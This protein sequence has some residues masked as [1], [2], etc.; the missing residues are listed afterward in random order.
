MTFREFRNGLCILR[1]LDR[2]ALVEAGVI[3]HGDHIRWLA[4]KDSPYE[5]TLEL[6]GERTKRLWELM[7]KRGMTSNTGDGRTT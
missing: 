5:R 2:H 3:P 7:Q 4:F 1:S 6:D